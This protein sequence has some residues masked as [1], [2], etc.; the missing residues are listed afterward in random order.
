MK[1]KIKDI[2]ESVGVEDLY[3]LQQDL[4]YG[5]K[6][7]KKIVDEKISEVEE[8]KSTYCLTCGKDLNK[9]NG[10]LSL[11]FGDEGLKKKAAFCELDCLEYFVAELKTLRNKVH[12]KQGGHE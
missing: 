11:T 2:I 10:S 9:C 7:L 12:D 4:S 1:Y 5:G 8:T 6:H 3:K